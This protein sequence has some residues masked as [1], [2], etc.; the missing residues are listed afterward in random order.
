[1]DAQ[2]EL[3]LNG[4]NISLYI[5]EF[6]LTDVQYPSAGDAKEPLEYGCQPNAHQVSNTFQSLCDVVIM[7][8]SE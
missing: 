2:I 3:C 8:N 1:M 6:T 7:Y 5:S 4:A